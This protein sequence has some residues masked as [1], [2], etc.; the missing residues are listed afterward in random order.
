MV[1]YKDKKV[2]IVGLG[3]TGL[4]CIDFFLT[5]GVIPR[6]IDTNIS[7][8]KFKMVPKYIESHLGGFN[9]DWLLK[10]DLIVI[11]PGVSLAHP[12]LQ[13]AIYKGID[14]VGDIELFCRELNVPIIAITGSNGKSTVT[15]LVKEMAKKSGYEVGVGG[16]IGFP[17]LKLLKMP[18]KQLYILEI[19]SFQLEVTNSLQASVA[20]VLN[21][22]E[23]HLNRYPLGLKQYQDTKMRIYKNALS[24]V[25][26]KD[27]LLT[28]PI[29]SKTQNFIS[30]GVKKGDYHL[31][32]KNGKVWIK[33]MFYDDIFNTEEMKIL[34]QHN[35]INA[36][37]ALA[38]AGSIGFP[39]NSSL[40]ALV[41]FIGLK[42]RFQLIC[43]HNN[44]SWIN[45][46]K[47]TNIKST[48]AALCSLK[49]DYYRFTL[50]LLLGGDS[51]NADFS[52]LMPYIFNRNIKI[53]CFGRDG[54]KIANLYPNISTLTETMQ[55]AVKQITILA[56]PGDV[57]LLSPACASFDQFDNFEHRGDTFIKL[58]K[59]IVNN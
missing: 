43:K 2:V 38:L 40:S 41:S 32:N 7:P 59:K 37:S 18:I 34:G 8:H 29:L 16:N 15:A 5:K 31:I 36:L 35:H 3:I 55:Q 26:N 22:S 45:D 39:Y 9:T 49:L 6:V 11:S 53:F 56:R 12:D 10:A 20:T 17:V 52:L 50:W 51:K 1:D 19:S 44:I 21:I 57:V 23:D 25:I 42:H 48:E 54:N 27:D 58:V 33:S 46:S 47:A 28:V 14:I 4:S 24:C 30:F 13:Q